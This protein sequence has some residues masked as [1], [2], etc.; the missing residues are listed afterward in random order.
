M[1]A[2][3]HAQALKMLNS[4]AKFGGGEKVTTVNSAVLV[5]TV[6]SQVWNSKIGNL[7][8]ALTKS[9]KE[10]KSTPSS[11]FFVSDNGRVLLVVCLF[12]GWSPL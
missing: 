2:Q 6:N 4:G 12:L 1:L 10:K 7:N 5:Q 8:K 3:L 9:E 11:F